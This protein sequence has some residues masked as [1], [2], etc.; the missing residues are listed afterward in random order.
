MLYSLS[1]RWIWSIFV[2]LLIWIAL[3]MLAPW[4]SAASSP[5]MH[6]LAHYIYL[7]FKP[8]CHQLPD[9]SFHWGL[10]QFAVCIRCFAFYTA[11]L[12]MAGFYLFHAQLKMLPL[13]VYILLSAPLLIDFLLEKLNIYSDLWILRFVTG[14]MAGLVFFHLLLLG[15]SE[16]KY[17]QQ[18]G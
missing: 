3:I 10:Y 6:K 2:F 7:L 11:G 15:V 18:D 13:R 14:F 5:A 12:I 1:R 17:T 9:R 4:L 8:T 16:K